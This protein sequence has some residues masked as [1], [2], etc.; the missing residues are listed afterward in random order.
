MFRRDCINLISANIMTEELRDC[1]FR[2]RGRVLAL[3]PCTLW[4][5]RPPNFAH[6][7]LPTTRRLGRQHLKS[8]DCLLVH[9]ISLKSHSLIAHTSLPMSKDANLKVC[10]KA[11]R[12]QTASR[13]ACHWRQYATHR[14]A[15]S[16]SCRLLLSNTVVQ[17]L[18]PGSLLPTMSRPP[19]YGCDVY[20]NGFG[21]G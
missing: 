21:D 14:S 5:P 3:D 17:S 19:C 7:I 4:A 2:V 11:R 9:E 20:S 13:Y 1:C 10:P 16:I 18:P 15:K 8:T 6:Y 12:V